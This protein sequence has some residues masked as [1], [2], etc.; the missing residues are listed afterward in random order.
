[1]TLFYAPHGFRPK[2]LWPL[3]ALP[4]LIAVILILLFDRDLLDENG[5]PYSPLHSAFIIIAAGLFSILLI[6]YFFSLFKKRV[7]LRIESGQI[8]CF[9]DTALLYRKLPFS[10]L[11]GFTHFY[12][13][14]LAKRVAGRMINMSYRYIVLHF[15][16]PHCAWMIP[17]KSFNDIR[18]LK[19]F[20]RSVG[21]PETPF[22]RSMYPKT[23]LYVPVNFLYVPDEGDCGMISDH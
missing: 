13:H 16:Q 1:M 21:V 4:L 12:E 9:E 17:E 18:G 7:V 19:S 15:Q 10:S 8:S 22:A 2:N 3:L 11:V 14:S 23:A 6:A 5:R 20:L